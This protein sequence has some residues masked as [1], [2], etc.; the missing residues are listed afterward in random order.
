MLSGDFTGG[1]V[2]TVGTG[3]ALELV[4]VDITGQQRWRV[5]APGLVG[6]RTNITPQNIL[7]F[8]KDASDGRRVV[9]LNARTGVQVWTMPLETGDEVLRNLEIREGR[10]VCAPGVEHRSRS[11]LHATPII[12]NYMG[13]TNLAADGRRRSDYGVTG[14]H[15]S[16]PR[17]Q[18]LHDR[19][20]RACRRIPR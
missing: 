2:M 7:Y 15:T 6:P 19:G 5:P 3:D 12:T 16:R 4:N 10:I 14:R 8:L 1:V 13:A 18:E 20:P 9:G 17:G 11:P